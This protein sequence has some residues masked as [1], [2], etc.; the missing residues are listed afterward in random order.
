MEETQNEVMEEV[1]EPT[2]EER[3]TMLESVVYQQ[4]MI[5]R[6]MAAGIVD[7]ALVSG[8]VQVKSKDETNEEKVNETTSLN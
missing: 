7:V 5:L 6:K 1:K 3:I 2:L 8:L 4:Q